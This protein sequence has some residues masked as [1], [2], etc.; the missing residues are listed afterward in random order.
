[1]ICEEGASSVQ[2]LTHNCWYTLTKLAND[3][4]NEVK[5]V[6]INDYGASKESKI[7]RFYV[8]GTGNSGGTNR[9]SSHSTARHGRLKKMVLFLLM[10]P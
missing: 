9:K 10:F 3:T 8:A 1:M 4:M 7:F 5:L 6:A 2:T